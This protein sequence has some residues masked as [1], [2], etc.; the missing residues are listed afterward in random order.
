MYTDTG[1]LSYKAP[2]MLKSSGYD[3]KVDMWAIGVLCYEMLTGN[4]P[5]YFDS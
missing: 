5:F 1:T 2:E 3:K 4:L